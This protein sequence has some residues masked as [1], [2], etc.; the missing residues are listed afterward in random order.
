MDYVLLLSLASSESEFSNPVRL[1]EGGGP[2][3][4]QGNVE[5]LYAGA[6]GG[7]CDDYWSFSEARVVC[8]MLGYSDAMRAFSK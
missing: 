2:G 4:H 6:W 3:A 8:H 1:M 5:I 7:V